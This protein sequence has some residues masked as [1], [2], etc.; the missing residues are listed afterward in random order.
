MLDTRLHRQQPQDIDQ[1]GTSG[2]VWRPFCLVGV[3]LILRVKSISIIQFIL[4]AI[5]SFFAFFTIFQCIE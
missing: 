1:G 5:P 4:F 3:V 2:T